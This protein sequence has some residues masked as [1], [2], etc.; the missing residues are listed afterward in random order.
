MDKISP[1]VKGLMIAILVVVVIV[2]ATALSFGGHHKKVEDKGLG[3][4]FAP[5][6]QV[7]VI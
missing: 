7:I 6:A 4:V 1:G 5:A 3:H 2:L